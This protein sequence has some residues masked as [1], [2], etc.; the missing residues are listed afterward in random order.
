MSGAVQLTDTG[1]VPSEPLHISFAGVN[2]SQELDRSFWGAVSY[3]VN[4]FLC[5]HGTSDE[6]SELIVSI[7]LLV[8]LLEP[9][10]LWEVSHICC[11]KVDFPLWDLC[12]TQSCESCKLTVRVRKQAW[13]W[14]QDQFVRC[15]CTLDGPVDLSLWGLQWM[16]Q[17]QSA[18]CGV[19]FPPWWNDGLLSTSSVRA[20][21][22]SL[23]KFCS[24]SVAGSQPLASC[25]SYPSGAILGRRSVD[26][27][28]CMDDFDAFLLRIREDGPSRLAGSTLALQRQI[29]LPVVSVFFNVFL[30]LPSL[31]YFWIDRLPVRQL[32][33]VLG[34]TSN[35]SAVM[36]AG[37][38]QNG[39][40]DQASSRRRPAI[41][42]GI[43]CLQDTLE[44]LLA[45]ASFRFLSCLLS[46]LVQFGAGLAGFCRSM[47]AISLC[48]LF[49][50]LLFSCSLKGG[51]NNCDNLLWAARSSVEAVPWQLGTGLCAFSPR[52]QGGAFSSRK[53]Q[54]GRRYSADLL[55]LLI[56][57]SALISPTRA[58]NSRSQPTNPTE[59][60]TVPAYRDEEAVD[61]GLLMDPD[62]A[63]DW[64]PQP[65][66]LNPPPPVYVTRAYKLIGFGRPP[67]YISSTTTQ[68]ATAQRCL[69]LLAP[70][71][72]ASRS[73]GSGTL[74]FSRG[75][76]VEDELQAQWMP[77]WVNNALGRLVVI[78]AS[79]LGFTPFQTFIQDGIISYQRV[80]RLMPELD[81][82]EF[83]IF[84]PSQDNDPLAFEGYPSRMILDHGDVIHL[85]P[86]PAPPQ[87]VQDVQWAFDHFADW[88]FT[89][90]ADGYD[91]P[92]S[93][94]RIF[95]L[96]ERENFLLEAVDGESD[97]SLL[98]RI[99]ADLGIPD[100]GASLVRPSE[101]FDRPMHCQYH[102][103]DI[104][105]LAEEPL[106]EHELVVFVDSRPV[107][108]TFSA[109]RLH[110]PVVPIG[111]AIE[112]FKLRVEAIE[113]YRL[114]LKGGRRGR[115]CLIAEHRATFSVRLEA[116]GV[117]YTSDSGSDTDSSDETSDSDDG[118]GPGNGPPGADE[119]QGTTESMTPDDVPP[120][121]SS[122]SY[123]GFAGTAAQ[124]ASDRI[125]FALERQ[126]CAKWN[127]AFMQD[128]IVHGWHGDTS[129][130]QPVSEAS[131]TPLSVRTDYVSFTQGALA[132]CN[133]LWLFGIVLIAHFK[134]LY[135]AAGEEYC[136]Q[137]NYDMSWP[138]LSLPCTDWHASCESLPAW[139]S[140]ASEGDALHIGEL[141]TL[142]EDAK[143]EGY[144]L[145]CS[146][147][148]DL[149]G[150]AVVPA[151]TENRSQQ[152]SSVTISLD[153]AI[154]HTAFQALVAEMLAILPGRHSCEFSSWQGWLD[155]DLQMISGEC[156]ACPAIWDWLSKFGTWYD[157]T[158]SPEMIHVYTDGSAFQSRCGAEATASWAFNVWALTPTK[159]AYMGHAFGVT[160]CEQS[161][162][163][164]GEV[165]NEAMTGE[166]LAL[167]WALSWAIEASCAFPLA[168]FVF[169][170]DSLTA[171]H[172]GFGVFKL[173]ADGRTSR[174]SG[175][176]R[177][178]AVLRQCA[179]AVCNIVGRHV[180][181]HA[182]HAGNE[183]ADVLAKYAAKHPVPDDHVSRPL[184]P[185]LVV[186]HSLAEWAWLTLSHQQDLPVLGAFESEAGRMFAEAASRPFTF[187]AAEN[188]QEIGPVQTS[189][190]IGV[191][192][193]LCTLNVLSLRE[194]DQ[195]PQGLAVV[196][197]RALLKQQL[198]ASR[199]HVL[200]LQETRMQGDCV[201]PDADF[202]MLHSSCDHQ[203]CYGCALWLSKTVPVIHSPQRSYY[204]TKDI[205]TVVLAEPR[206]LIVQVDL[207]GLPLTLVSAHAPYD[208]HRTL[209]PESFWRQVDE[210]VA[211]RP[212]GAQ[213]VVL[214]D[215][216]G[217]LGSASSTAVGTAGAEHENKPGEAFHA[218]LV[219]FGLCLPSTFP[220]LHQGGHLTWKVGSPLGHRLDY[221]AVPDGWLTGDVTSSVWYDFDH[222][223]DVDDHQPVLL[224]C[225]LVRK[226]TKGHK[227]PPIRAPRPQPDSDPGQLQCFQ[228]AVGALPAVGWHVNV[229]VHYADFVR[230]T[231]WCWSEFVDPVPRKRNKPFIS[232]GTLDTIAQRKQVRQLL[233]KEEAS[234]RRVRLQAGFFAFWLQWKHDEPT[235][236][237]THYF[238]NLLQNGRFGL[239]FAVGSLGRLRVSLRKAIR[240]DRAAYLKKLADEVAGSSLRQPRQLFAA[241][242]KAFPVV[243]SKRKSGFCPLP[244]VLLE[245]GNKA[246]D[247]TERLQ[248]WTEHFAGQE[249]GIIVN[250]AGYDQAVRSQTPDPHNVPDF[251]IGCVPTLL[252]IEQDIHCLRKGK[253][254]GPDHITADLLKLD[255]PHSS[256]RLLPIFAKAALS[257]REPIIFKGGCLITLAKKAYASLNC[258]DF[259]SIMLSSVP[260]K[261]LH[262]SLRRKL[263]TPLSEVALP[264]QAGALPGAS[265]EL[266]TLY[267]TA[268]Q[269]W[270][271]SNKQ[272]WAVTFFDVKQAYYRTLRQ[273]V[274]DCDSDEGLCG[275]LHA[276]PLAGRQ[277]LNALLRDLL[278]ATWFKFEASHMVAVTHKGTRPGDPAADVIFAF[279]LSALFRAIDAALRSQDLVDD[280]PAARQIP[281][282]ATPTGGNQLQFVSWAD[283]FARPFLGDTPT[284]LL[285]KVRQATKCCT[286]RASSCG[287]ELTFGLDKTA[288]VFGISSVHSLREQ[289]EDVLAS[290]I[291]FRDDTACKACVLPVVP[292]YR[293]LGG[294]FSASAK[295]DLEIF[296]RRAA[297][298]GPIRPIRSKLFAN[299]AVPLATRRTLLYSL[300]L[301]RF[302]HGAGALHL[303]QR[304][305]QRAWHSAYVSIWAHLLPGLP[306][307]K[308]HS[309]QVMS[310]SKAPPPHLFLALQRAALLTKLVS[311][312]FAAILHTLQLEYE[313][314]QGRSWLSQILEDI[315][316][317][318]QWIPAVSNLQHSC[319]PLHELCQLVRDSPSWWVLA[320]RQAVK[321]V[322]ADIAKWKQMPKIVAVPDG[323]DFACHICSDTFSQRNFLTVHL[324]RKHQLFAPAR[325]FVTGRQCISCLR[326][327][328]TVMLA[329]SH[330]R[331]TPGCFKRAVWLM[332]PLSIEE[333]VAVEKEDKQLRKKI[334]CG[335]WQQHRVVNRAMQGAGPLNV[336]AADVEVNPEAFSI[337]TV[338]RQFRPSRSVTQWIADYLEA[339]SS[340]G[341]RQRAVSWWRSRPTAA[342][343]F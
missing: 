321:A 11:E 299:R 159:Q 242:Y 61:R 46:L 317:V 208:G 252:D 34:S 164:L 106:G 219:R 56:L 174:P 62:I 217:H 147:I 224:S 338:A 286:E 327:F 53:S 96:S 293:H 335:G 51:V 227:D 38:M 120:Q 14:V 284:G 162:F 205:C 310:V 231:L 296:L 39:S 132:P 254:A 141:V 215:S 223:H 240:A 303:D 57:V 187:Y 331:R 313:T 269:R 102:L 110:H 59:F 40:L 19:V 121:A 76:A 181:S 10:N 260:G 275:V 125:D 109:I 142:L 116:E 90:F 304:G 113:G 124:P 309:Y 16:G 68:T 258:A 298:I 316:A 42:P 28:R 307:G 271:E 292:A 288:S 139:S 199:L 273:L 127:R 160:T 320:I 222:V 256:R 128:A 12:L 325:H 157:A 15:I 26:S 176:S 36:P 339:A 194:S 267:L 23:L 209:S 9:F 144:C 214:A 193:C 97:N 333:V 32:V 94:L 323:G 334:C 268:F 66:V 137:F 82:S 52:L 294:I 165:D 239:A 218:F 229:D 198:L 18:F 103:S 253:A 30:S 343:S 289:G 20:D 189:V 49:R 306:K 50:L 150:A 13:V 1:H 228:Y 241:V 3:M 60:P 328:A 290:G 178:V 262:R 21:G 105:F 236:L 190:D 238:A 4:C 180:P 188:E 279:T 99:C 89:E 247:V 295:P 318:A 221:I 270:A 341:P 179:Q 314:A 86:D 131:R 226:D 172:G 161:P 151:A 233:L 25:T 98:Q 114:W 122:A 266:L 138:Q 255:V 156:K 55:F 149:W 130:R 342:N 5:G 100:D 326:T 88:S 315:Q 203:G 191:H 185:S 251:D 37:R 170:F 263:V 274:V 73:G 301:S 281:L 119:G 35:N 154:P 78:D 75:P 69:E 302:I 287:I 246:R 213:L 158:F 44:S 336:T 183:L 244:A 319:W 83:F 146:F 175:L 300:G 216:N 243:K 234:L 261:L 145:V 277:H 80:H 311:P 79:L 173:P 329:Q 265:P 117:V 17:W 171:G 308:P 64:E 280:L 237:H 272:N 204:F 212:S 72:E 257:C 211:S 126:A 207:P 340:S 282:L 192:L 248:R 177:S 24:T 92:V 112:L 118:Q 27:W 104:V 202:V 136:P 93:N 152:A 332:E 206:L 283:D 163:H 74:Q 2:H 166:Q 129:A 264:L 197:K 167:A 259:R 210:C 182:G 186:K 115:D 184:W 47:C 245:D 70:D 249:G 230:S 324:A 312:C 84:I 200:A 22:L 87:A 196:G 148:S 101:P 95:V 155:C 45:A 133:R 285:D 153:Q 135:A 31:L 305:H 140:P 337:T 67:E 81:G 65:W 85:T 58:A 63:Q 91:V 169:H 278:T 77:D 71:V 107:L 41:L 33:L 134:A 6:A 123:S 291:C 322:A 54:V 250:A 225:L 143:D 276:S 201:Q 48:Y 195:V 108:Q 232:A 7:R 43:E 330:L 297:A 29:L 111:E 235:A 8:W 168:V 220:E